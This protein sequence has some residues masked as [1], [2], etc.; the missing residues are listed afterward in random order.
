MT[1]KYMENLGKWGCYF[2]CIV[3]LAELITGK[4]IDAVREYSHC[5]QARWM[6][7]DCYI[8][9]PEEIMYYL[10]GVK[11]TVRHEPASYFPTNGELVIQRWGWRPPMANEEKG[12]FVLADYDPYGDSETVK[13][14][15][16][17]SYRVF[18]SV[19]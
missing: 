10:T 5:T 2:L 3:R 11:W 9:K 15:S 18:K 12:H 14:G 4:S 13:N 7:W 8:T 19:S 6:R 1:Q 17:V 16:L